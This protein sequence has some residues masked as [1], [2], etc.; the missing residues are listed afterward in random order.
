MSYCLK[1]GEESSI[2]PWLDFLKIAIR[3]CKSCVRNNVSH[4]LSSLYFSF[5]LC[6]TAALAHALGRQSLATVSISP[7]VTAVS[8]DRHDM[9]TGT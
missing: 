3:A 6:S 1:V 4:L 8:K 9:N 7:T 2:P 5:V